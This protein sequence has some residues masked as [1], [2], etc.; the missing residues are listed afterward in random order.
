MMAF[1]S[2]IT[3]QIFSLARNDLCSL[4]CVNKD[5]NRLVCQDLYNEIYR[6]GRI[7]GRQEW[8]NYFGDPGEVPRI[9]ISMMAKYNGDHHFLT[10]VPKKVVRSNGTKREEFYIA[11]SMKKLAQNPLKGHRIGYATNSWKQKGPIEETHW[12]LL[13]KTVVDCNQDFSQQTK[14]AKEKGEN[15]SM[16]IDTIVTLFAEYV[17]SG[18]PT[19]PI[20]MRVQ[21]SFELRLG[22]RG[23]I[24][25]FGPDGLRLEIDEGNANANIG[26][27]Y[28]CKS[29]A[30]RKLGVYR[31]SLLTFINARIVH[32]SATNAGNVFIRDCKSLYILIH[33]FERP[34]T[35]LFYFPDAE[36]CIP[37]FVLILSYMSCIFKDWF[38]FI[39]FT[40][41]PSRGIMA[42]VS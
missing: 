7:F 23:L 16:L 20:S 12:V 19:N 6:T 21:D 40:N 30:H 39:I 17:R 8:I 28:A 27:V 38:S 11:N 34:V 22:T 36:T 42:S 5:W 15:I 24:V 18:E 33:R 32:V 2:H 41:S 13:S 25:G 14:I 31:F 3:M 9:P 4:A 29:N 1:P 37:T 10:L 35:F 26:V